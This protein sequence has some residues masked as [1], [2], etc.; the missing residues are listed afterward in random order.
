MSDFTL[1]DP[2]GWEYDLQSVSGRLTTGTPRF[3]HLC[4]GPLRLHV[5]FPNTQHLMVRTLL[6]QLAESTRASL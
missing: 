3:Y 5:A 6:S 2:R 1:V 4:A